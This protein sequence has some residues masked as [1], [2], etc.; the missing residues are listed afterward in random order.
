[1]SLWPNRPRARPPAA[2]DDFL[3]LAVDAER[4]REVLP[5][6]QRWTVVGRGSSELL[7]VVGNGGSEIGGPQQD[8][9]VVEHRGD[10][11]REPVVRLGALSR[12]QPMRAPTDTASASLLSIVYISRR[13][14]R[15][16]R[17]LFSADT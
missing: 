8:D 4:L 5:I 11:N 12:T 14:R 13:A 10:L 15:V 6:A 16:A 9:T 17:T 1:M 7:P 3:Q 2:P